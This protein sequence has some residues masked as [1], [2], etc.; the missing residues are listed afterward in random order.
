VLAEKRPDLADSERDVIAD[1]IGIGAVKYADLSSERIRDYVFDVERMLSFEGNTAPYLQ[2]AFVRIQSIFRNAGDA[3]TEHGSL[4]IEHAS[5]RALAVHVLRFP[6][7]VASVAT[8]LEPHR[9]CGYLYDLASA[10]HVFYHACRVLNAETEEIRKSRLELCRLVSRTL[11]LGL[12]LL[13]IP[14]IDRM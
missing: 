10:F 8:T 13:G 3:A 7:V 12:S 9:L 2:N 5:E 14:V 1:G 4:R 6:R 11:A